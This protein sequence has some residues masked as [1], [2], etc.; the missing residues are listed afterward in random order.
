[1]WVRDGEDWTI[2]SAQDHICGFSSE[3]REARTQLQRSLEI[4]LNGSGICG[5][6]VTT[7][8]A[9]LQVAQL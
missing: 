3:Y 2:S 5:M 9:W 8:L 1:M 6:R 4:L 7:G